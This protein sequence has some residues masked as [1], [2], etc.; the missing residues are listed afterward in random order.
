MTLL[1]TQYIK[2][3]VALFAITFLLACS[4]KNEPTNGSNQKTSIQGA[5]E[6]GPFVRGSVVTVYELNSDLNPT[7]R[8]FKS[9]ILDDKGSFSLTD[10]E[11]ASNYV[12]L[13]V[14]GYY[15]N[16]VNGNLSTSQITLN[17]LA[18]ITNNKSI[19]VNVLSHLEEKRVRS[20]MKKD[21]KS[22]IE[23]KKQALAE[24]YTSFYV[25]TSPTTSSELLSLTKND[26]NSNILLGISAALL[27][28]SQSDNAKLTE[29][30][31]VLSTD[32]DDNGLIDE[33]LKQ[34]IKQSLEGLNS[35][36]I[37]DNLKNRYKALNITLADFSIDKAFSVEI[38]GEVI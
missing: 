16:E 15:F 38:K 7:G 32:F 5:V 29:L 8:S 37:S 22:F 4:K 23:A 1:N 31:S 36:T 24:I 3:F 17:A 12:Q 10:I 35:K 25:K 19:N 18:D 27:N 6:K 28:I 21:K 11:L 14:N 13:S 33:S 30:L 9:E 26:D 20:L 2:A 34:V